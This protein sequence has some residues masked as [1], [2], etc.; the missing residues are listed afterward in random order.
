MHKN[1]PWLKLHEWE[2]CLCV[3]TMAGLPY[4]VPH[5]N[6]SSSNI[7]CI[8]HIVQTNV[9]IMPTM[10]TLCQHIS[11]SN[12]HVVPMLFIMGIPESSKKF[13]RRITIMC[14]KEFHVVPR[15][16]MLCQGMTELSM[17]Y[18][19]SRKCQE[20]PC[21]AKEWQTMGFPKNSKSW[22]S[23]DRKMPLGW[24]PCNSISCHFL[25]A[26]IPK[27]CAIHWYFM[28]QGVKKSSA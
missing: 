23:N 12:F 25:D 13:Q 26:P 15:N 21:C 27:Y 24:V 20:I 2:T 17:H 5:A 4:W 16:S 9:Y 22:N 1:D 18:G 3:L 19:N 28:V 6:I 7:N 10:C 11:S 14:A 8:C